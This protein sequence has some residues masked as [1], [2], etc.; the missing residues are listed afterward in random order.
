MV[1]LH[2]H[3][4]IFADLKSNVIEYDSDMSYPQVLDPSRTQTLNM[5]FMESTVKIDDNLWDIFEISEE[6]TAKFFE[7]T[8]SWSY[9]TLVSTEAEEEIEYLNI[10]FRADNKQKLY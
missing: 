1:T 7:F 2:A 4:N 9:T 10:Y 5:A 3:A 6:W 8:Q